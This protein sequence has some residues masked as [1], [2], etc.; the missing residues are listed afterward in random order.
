MTLFWRYPYKQ[1]QLKLIK[2]GNEIEW[3]K[4]VTWTYV[5][6][7]YKRFKNGKSGD[8]MVEV[9]VDREK[10]SNEKRHTW[11]SLFDCT[12]STCKYHV[13]DRQIVYLKDSVNSYTQMTT[14]SYL[15]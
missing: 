12:W 13:W 14:D 5:Y 6:S 9:R 3:Y 4:L 1:F 11:I 10:K 8:P 2:N 7:W 15:Q